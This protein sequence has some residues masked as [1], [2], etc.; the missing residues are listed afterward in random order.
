VN[1]SRAKQRVLH[2]LARGGLILHERDGRRIVVVSCMDRE[3]AVLSD[4]TLAVFK[5]LRRRGLIESRG[6]RP[7]RIAFAGRQAVRAQPDNRQ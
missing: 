3:G 2:V 7:Y 4:C 6:G 5:R 1:I